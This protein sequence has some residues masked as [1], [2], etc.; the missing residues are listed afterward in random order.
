MKSWI[1][2]AISALAFAARSETVV[3]KLDPDAYSVGASLSD[4]RTPFGEWGDVPHGFRIAACP[5]AIGVGKAVS[6]N[7]KGHASKF[8]LK[9]PLWDDYTFTFRF[10]RTKDSND[11][12][13]FVG[14]G[15]T[16]S[17]TQAGLSISADGSIIYLDGASP[18]KYKR[19]A[20]VP[21]VF[22]SEVGTWHVAALVVRPDTG[23]TGA[24]DIRI[25]GKSI[26]Q[27][28]SFP[29][30]SNSM[31]QSVILRASTA[32]DPGG[33]SILLDDFE[34]T[35]TDGAGGKLPRFGVGVKPVPDTLGSCF[36][37]GDPIQFALKVEGYFTDDRIRATWSLSPYYKPERPIQDQ[38]AL[39]VDERGEATV[40]L[41]DLPRGGYWLRVHVSYAGK[42]VTDK[43]HSFA[44]LSAPPP[45]P[46]D[47][48]REWLGLVTHLEYNA[49]GSAQFETDLRI[50]NL[51]GIRW[52]RMNHHWDWYHRGQDQQPALEHRRKIADRL[53]KE[54][55]G[56][57]EAIQSTPAWASSAPSN[58]HA[59]YKYPPRNWDW[60]RIYIKALAEQLKGTPAQYMIWCE[61][62]SFMSVDRTADRWPGGLADAVAEFGRIAEET[63]HGVSPEAVVMGPASSGGAPRWTRIMLEKYGTFYNQITFHYPRW[64]NTP[65]SVNQRILRDIVRYADRP[66]P[67]VTDEAGSL[68]GTAP[69]TE[70]DL[71]R[72]LRG[73][74]RQWA[75]GITNRFYSFLFRH[76][77]ISDSPGGC[78]LTADF[79]ARPGVAVLQTLV[80]RTR[81]A[82]F[83]AVLDLGADLEGY[84][85]DREGR[86]GMIL[87]TK[88]GETEPLPEKLMASD[89]RACDMY[90]NELPVAGMK[91]GRQPI[92]LDGVNTGGAQI[93]AITAQ[94]RPYC[95][96]LDDDLAFPVKLTLANHAAV[97][98]KM[99]LRFDDPA[100]EVTPA[101]VSRELTPGQVTTVPLRIRAR[102]KRAVSF[103]TTPLTAQ[104][105]GREQRVAIVYHF[106][107]TR[108]RTIDVARFNPDNDFWTK[109]SSFRHAA[110][111]AV[112]DQDLREFRCKPHPTKEGRYVGSF[113]TEFAAREKPS[114]LGAHFSRGEPLAIPGIPFRVRFR[115]RATTRMLPSTAALLCRF[116]DARGKSIQF[117]GL[118]PWIYPSREANSRTYECTIDSPITS[119]LVHSQW[120]GDK[121]TMYYPLSFEGFSINPTPDRPP[122]RWIGD[123][124]V[125]AIE[126]DYYE[127]AEK[128]EKLPHRRIDNMRA[129]AN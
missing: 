118:A 123:I 65:R 14:V 39:A 36:I 48:D 106:D 11:G 120:G 30:G 32:P 125:E 34:I 50:I 70:P 97:A 21:A 78:Y 43:E 91:I 57:I 63:I 56:W 113:H 9:K 128:I 23:G 53:V 107:D 124:E 10:N 55:I 46:N 75:E 104:V 12:E 116:V 98:R 94:I 122:G 20:V 51:L 31:T 112:E 88:G 29:W 25:D 5:K 26:V 71:A 67:M 60:W 108:T 85:L 16:G 64:P 40:S 19:T 101:T 92:Y 8:L 27:G 62:C 119:Q 74:V 47:V 59:R 58:G 95:F 86:R 1:A 22:A 103:A 80:A 99:N 28:V 79:Q 90:G 100:V 54:G 35:T 115:V 82:E 2:V 73:Y 3:F 7:W 81:N 126:M 44:V 127:P 4:V 52:I 41:S 13:V 61:P 93:A 129:I 49:P 45:P 109:S 84:L 6:S 83:I 89:L 87:W 117:H 121:D 102:P 69:G 96:R 68:A 42:L 111:D 66:L 24:Y 37:H 17:A 105:N 72:N 76:P 77:K 114:W 33:R 38:V 15:T 18:G 110:A